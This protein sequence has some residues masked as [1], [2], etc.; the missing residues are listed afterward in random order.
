MTI[1]W[2]VVIAI[3]GSIEAISVVVIGGIFTSHS[4]KLELKRA[5]D[6]EEDLAYRKKREEQEEQRQARDAVMYDLVFAEA[7]GTEVVLQVMQG[8]KING[9]VSSALDSLKRAKSEANKLVNRQAAS[10]R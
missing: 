10:I 1:P 5:E 3:I 9:N 6:R 2:D 4:K 7:T 8:D